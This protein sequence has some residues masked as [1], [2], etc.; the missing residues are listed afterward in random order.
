MTE[1]G[2]LGSFFILSSVVATQLSGGELIEIKTTIVQLAIP[3]I[4]VIVVATG[5]WWATLVSSLIL[6]QYIVLDAVVSNNVTEGTRYNELKRHLRGKKGYDLSSPL[7]NGNL[8][9]SAGLDGPVVMLT[10]AAPIALMALP[11]GLALWAICAD[12]FRIIALAETWTLVW[13]LAATVLG[14]I[15]CSIAYFLMYFVPMSIGKNLREI[16]WGFLSPLYSR[17]GFRHP[18]SE[19]WLRR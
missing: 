18:R 11:I 17:D 4:Y 14:A 5:Y 15:Y 10:Y 12:T 19:C 1:L 6:L 3:K 16:R 8:H 2:K 7:R 13:G 9:S